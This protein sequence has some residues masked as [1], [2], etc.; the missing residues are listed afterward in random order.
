MNADIIFFH[1]YAHHL[2]FQIIDRPLPE[3][4]V[5]GFA[6][7]MSTVRFGKERRHWDRS[8]RA[9]HRAWGLFGGDRLPLATM[10]SGNY[11]KITPEQRKSIYGRGWLLVHYLTFEKS[12]AGQ[13]ER[14]VDMMSKG[15]PPLAA[16]R[17]AFGDLKQA[18]SGAQF[19][20]EPQDARLSASP[21]FEVS[22]DPH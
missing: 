21:R 15:T 10:L 13:L 2:M 20:F 19:I 14:Y 8:A 1:E 9:N 11:T 5:E 12:R 16:A 17:S 3:W 18:R 7:F 22:D 6:E 4:V